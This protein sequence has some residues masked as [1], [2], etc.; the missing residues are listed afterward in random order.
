MSL[1]WEIQ[2]TFLDLNYSKLGN[3]F[4]PNKSNLL[5]LLGIFLL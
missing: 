3:E 1:K 2:N 5:L 4:I